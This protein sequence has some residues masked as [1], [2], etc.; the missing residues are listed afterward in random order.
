MI[1]PFNCNRDILGRCVTWTGDIRSTISARASVRVSARSI[2]TSAGITSRPH[3]CCLGSVVLRHRQC[4]LSRACMLIGKQHDFC[5]NLLGLCDSLILISMRSVEVGLTYGDVPVT[6]K[7]LKILLCVPIHAHIFSAL[8]F[9]ERFLL[10][11]FPVSPG[12]HTSLCEEDRQ[13]RY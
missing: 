9:G 11:E 13:D 6:E 5:S 4:C 3:D 12:C 2:G 1:I 7:V 10:I 8:V